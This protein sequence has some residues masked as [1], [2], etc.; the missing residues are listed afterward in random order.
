MKLAFVNSACKIPG[1]H[2]SETKFANYTA[3]AASLFCIVELTETFLLFPSAIF[4]KFMVFHRCFL[5]FVMFFPSVSFFLNLFPCDLSL[6]D[7]IIALRPSL[8]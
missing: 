2:T 5:D 1:H 3:F 8:E 4:S 6:Q 7:N